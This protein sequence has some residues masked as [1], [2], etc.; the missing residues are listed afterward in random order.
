MLLDLFLSILTRLHAFFISNTYKQRQ[1]EISKNQAKAK[2]H[3]QAKLLLFE[4]YLL[5]S[6]TLSS[7]HDRRYSKKYTK[8][9][10]VCLSEDI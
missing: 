8:N 4:N 3:P 9:K 1:A 10:Y 2:Q 5:S 6:S 7:K